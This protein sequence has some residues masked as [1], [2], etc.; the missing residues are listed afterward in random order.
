VQNASVASDATMWSNGKPMFL[1]ELWRSKSRGVDQGRGKVSDEQIRHRWGA[2]SNMRKTPDLPLWR[3]EEGIPTDMRFL[4]RDNF[5]EFSRR[6]NGVDAQSLQSDASTQEIGCFLKY[7]KFTISGLPGVKHAI[8][9]PDTL[10]LTNSVFEQI[11]DALGQEVPGLFINGIG[12]H[13]QPSQMSTPNLRKGSSFAELMHEAKRSLGKNGTPGQSRSEG[14]CFAGPQGRPNLALE[15]AEFLEPEPHSSVIQ[16]TNEVLQKKIESLVRQI[17]TVAAQANAWTITGPELSNLDLFL[18]QSLTGEQEEV[19]RLVFGH[20]QDQAYMESPFTQQLWEELF[21]SAQTMCAEAVQSAN[22]V[23]LPGNFW[24]MPYSGPP[25][26]EESEGTNAS[27]RNRDSA[28]G[29]R[30]PWPYGNLFLLFFR[31]D[32]AT[33]NLDWQYRTKMR[34]D[35]EAVPFA[36]ESFAPMA[37][38]CIGS[39]SGQAKKKLMRALKFANSPVMIVDNTANAHR[40]MSIFVNIIRLLWEPIPTVSCA[41]F[42]PEGAEAGLGGNATST[43]LLNAMLPG[44]ILNH[45]EKQFDSNGISPEEKFTLTDIVSLLN[46]VKQQPLSFRNMVCILDPLSG[47]PETVRVRMEDVLANHHSQGYELTNS[48]AHH[49]LVLRAWR[50]HC[51]LVRYARIL[52]HI[53]IAMVFSIGLIFVICTALSCFMLFLRLQKGTAGD[54]VY[55]ISFLFAMDR[56]ILT[57]SYSDV[58][59]TSWFTIVGLVILAGLLLVL[60]S[61]FQVT[62]RWARVNG[63]ANS[64]IADI[65]CFLGSVKPYRMAS[66]ANQRLFLKN[67]SDVSKLMLHDGLREEEL[68]GWDNARFAELA[69]LH[70]EIAYNLYGIQAESSCRRRARDLITCCEGPCGYWAWQA[71]DLKNRETIDLAAPLS[72]ETYMAVRVDPLQAHYVDL[73]RFLHRLH[74]IRNI[75]TLLCLVSASWMAYCGSIVWVPCPLALAAFIIMMVHWTAPPEVLPTVKR[76]LVV[77]GNQ[78]MWWQGSDIREHRLEKAKRQM[79]TMTEK[80]SAAVTA[81]WTRSAPVPAPDTRLPRESPKSG[82]GS[83]LPPESSRSRTPGL[84]TPITQSYTPRTIR[85]A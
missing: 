41:P 32:G 33:G 35:R 44:K 40:Q 56:V 54:E 82:E 36:P 37:Y 22:C 30:F 49:S 76:A 2:Q 27:S 53:D 74:N 12:S 72:A 73:L 46:H 24:E 57:Y 17:T 55:Q 65:Q 8:F 15:I 6:L 43:E 39:K 50:L 85:R 18:Q 45:I 60:Q 38:I 4:S 75:G 20:V 19:F 1:S 51:R 70:Q 78:R 48:M 58:T 61:H 13:C 31:E 80:L 79:I 64:L 84:R 26:D 25:V 77:L 14:A 63:T 11:C 68:S 69:A 52:R 9:I 3:H 5:G 59:R 71:L 62:Q 29:L 28:V 21:D 23:S 66:G 7:T 42:L 67:V 81:A 47:S 83:E 16:V 34:F 10:C